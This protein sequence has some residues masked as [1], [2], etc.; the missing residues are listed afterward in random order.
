MAYIV[1]DLRVCNNVISTWIQKSPFLP[2]TIL[3]DGVTSKNLEV[4]MRAAFRLWNIALPA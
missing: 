2:A 1:T 4:L 3:P